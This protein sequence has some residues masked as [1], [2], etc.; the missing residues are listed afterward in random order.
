RLRAM[1]RLHALGERIDCDALDAQASRTDAARD[2]R[3]E[4]WTA[5][6]RVASLDAEPI[7]PGR[8]LEALLGFVGQALPSALRGPAFAAGAELSARVGNGD[9][10]RRL[11][12]A[13]SGAA[14][15]LLERAGAEASSAIRLLPWVRLAEAAASGDFSPEQLADV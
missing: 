8:V 12:L 1:A 9:A 10:V 6:A 7:A 3:L 15:E 4:W 5:R 14:R 2:A 13:A 11:T